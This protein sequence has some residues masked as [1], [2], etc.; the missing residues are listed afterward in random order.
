[1]RDSRRARGPLLTVFDA[2]PQARRGLAAA[3]RLARALG[4]ELVILAPVG[5]GTSDRSA[6]VEAER[7]LAAEQVAG[8]ALP[9]RAERTSVLA[10]ARAHRGILLVLPLQVA[11]EWSPDIS[12]LAA[13]APC[14]LVIAR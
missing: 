5:S 1:L 13:D 11:A 4:S 6:R 7:W 12:A 2:S 8:I 14:P 3:T 9:V 10:A